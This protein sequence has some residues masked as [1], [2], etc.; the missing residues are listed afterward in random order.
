MKTGY[1]SFINARF[2][3]QKETVCGYLDKW[4][5]TWTNA[6]WAKSCDFNHLLLINKI[7]TRVGECI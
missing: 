4:Y 2:N 7:T 6:D 5:L 1:V 3:G